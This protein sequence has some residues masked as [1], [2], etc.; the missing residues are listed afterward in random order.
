VPYVEDAL[1]MYE[2]KGNVAMA[3]RAESLLTQIP[4]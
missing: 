3:E 4:A 2:E 1:A